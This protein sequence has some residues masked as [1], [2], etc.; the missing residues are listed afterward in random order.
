MNKITPIITILYFKSWKNHN[1]TLIFKTIDSQNKIK[2]NVLMN[3]VGILAIISP[4][5]IAFAIYVYFA[6]K[7]I[8][9]KLSE[10]EELK[11]SKKGAFLDSLR[12][13]LIIEVFYCFLKINAIATC[14]SI[15]VIL[16]YAWNGGPSYNDFRYIFPDHD[17]WPTIEFII[18]WIA[19]ILLV[20]VCYG[21]LAVVKYFIMRHILKK[22]G[23]KLKFKEMFSGLMVSGLAGFCILVAEFVFFIIFLKILQ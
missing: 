9:N 20:C 15:L 7:R 23:R 10:D 5:G 13:G 18:E 14:A 1:N 11:N 19:L 4:V 16:H 21:F 8:K 17:L 2:Y 22:N 12:I 3:I 6:N